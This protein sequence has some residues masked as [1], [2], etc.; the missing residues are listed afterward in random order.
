M[1]GFNFLMTES[2]IRRKLPFPNFE[3]FGR[4]CCV[5]FGLLVVQWRYPKPLH[6]GGQEEEGFPSFGAKP[7][8]LLHR[9]EV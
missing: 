1:G 9:K 6:P 4:V 2:E 8:P 5:V 7:P 3:V